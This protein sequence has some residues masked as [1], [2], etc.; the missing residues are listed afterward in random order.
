MGTRVQGPYGRDPSGQP[1]PMQPGEVS[2][3]KQPPGLFGQQGGRTRGVPR[4][5]IVPNP[6]PGADWSYAQSGPSFL[7]FHCAVSVLATSATVATRIARFQLKY[8]GVICG[9]FAAA[10][11]QLASLTNT[12]SLHPSAISS[13]DAATVYAPLPADLILRDGMSIGSNTTALQAGDQW[14]AIALFVEE[15]SD[16]TL[17]L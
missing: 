7:L 17:V 2:L 11:T 5:I 16:V 6:A 1:A 3:A 10:S 4:I 9:Q 15:F 13:G 8:T 12:Y 14:S